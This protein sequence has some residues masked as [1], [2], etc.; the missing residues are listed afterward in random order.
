M[1]ITSSSILLQTPQRDGRVWVVEQFIDNLG[2]SWQIV[3]LAPSATNIAAQ[4]T[5]D[6]VAMAAQLVAN[7]IAANVTLVEAL[8]SVAPVT[9]NYSALSGLLAA[10]AAAYPSAVQ[11][12]AIMIG[13]YLNTIPQ[14]S[15]MA[16]F[17]ANAVGYTNIKNNFL[18]P[19][20]A[21]ASTI[22]ATVGT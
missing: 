12:Q 2:F 13:D 20:A 9:F 5:V 19:A 3:Y 11:Y 4:L 15:I 18:T 1:T 16:A 21:A 14:A 6:S 10:L 7:E 17:G 8:G 22:R